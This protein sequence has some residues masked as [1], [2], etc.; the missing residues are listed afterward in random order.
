MPKQPHLFVDQ[1]GNR[2][3]AT[4]VKGLASQ[5]NPYA[6]APKARRMYVDGRDGKTYHVG[7]IVS[8]GRGNGDHWLTEYAPVRREVVTLSRSSGRCLC[9]I[10]VRG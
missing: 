10:A 5:I 1:Y 3:H 4:T 2:W 6:K 7:Y 8:A 9:S